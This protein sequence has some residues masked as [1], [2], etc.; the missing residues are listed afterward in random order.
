MIDQRRGSPDA[1][2]FTTPDPRDLHASAFHVLVAGMTSGV[3]TKLNGYLHGR[4][5]AR[6]TIQRL[7]HIVV[8]SEKRSRSFVF[9]EHVD[10]DMT[11]AF[12]REEA[13]QECACRCM[14]P[15]PTDDADVSRIPM[16]VA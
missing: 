8:N 13:A 15:A 7:A 12:V 14:N 10:L 6:L 11:D 5:L 3:I 4:V 9:F 1:I 2:R 16:A